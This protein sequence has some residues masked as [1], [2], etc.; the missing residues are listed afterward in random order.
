[1]DG[2]VILGELAC[3]GAALAWAVALTMFHGLISAHGAR[4]VNLVKCLVASVLLGGTTLALGQLGPLLTASPRDLA[5]VAVSGV[6][7]LSLGDSALFAAVGRVGV[8]RT[9]LLQSLAPIFTAVL[10]ATFLGERLSSGQGV[11]AAVI[12]AGVTLVVL[13]RGESSGK[14]LPSLDALGVLLGLLAALG[15]GAGIVLAKEGMEGMPF[16]PASF[17]RLTASALGLVV[18][19]ALAGRLGRAWRLLSDGPSLLLL[20][21]PTLLGSYL[22]I[23]MMTAGII[24]APA[25][26]AAVLLATTPVFSLFIDARLTGEPI[27]ARSLLGTLLAV[28]GVGLL[29]FSA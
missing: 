26:V 22:G 18:M 11:G 14:R 1:M 6:V 27:T 16:L 29:A 15:Q 7:G 5:L 23:L 19:V 2:K 28:L 21:K 3:L 25:S 9:L 4:A 20:A 13:Q 24:Y 8:Y 17:L 10:A 12:L